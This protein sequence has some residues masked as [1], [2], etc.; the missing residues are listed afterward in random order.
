VSVLAGRMRGK[1]FGGTLRCAGS[2]IGHGAVKR[3][4][5]GVGFWPG[6]AALVF[7]E[8]P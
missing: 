8:P 7:L 4:P 3:Q 5:A 1:V 6:L 2:Y